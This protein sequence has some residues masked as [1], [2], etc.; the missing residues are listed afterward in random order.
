[1]TTTHENRRDTF[2]KRL[3]GKVRRNDRRATIARKSAFLIDGLT[4]RIH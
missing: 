4:V 2:A 3:P 1:M